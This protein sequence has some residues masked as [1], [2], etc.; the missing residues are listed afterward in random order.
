MAFNA[1][2]Y[3]ISSLEVL[4]WFVVFIVKKMGDVR[5]ERAWRTCRAILRE[6]YLF[7]PLGNSNLEVIV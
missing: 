6:P 4:E 5:A 7:S 3:I 2:F 1:F